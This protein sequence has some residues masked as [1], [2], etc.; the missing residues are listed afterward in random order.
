VPL[1][2]ENLG[3]ENPQPGGRR[4]AP[5]RLAIVQGFINSRWELSSPGKGETFSTPGRLGDWLRTRG[6]IGRGPRLTDR[7][8]G[9][10]IAV[11]EGLRALAFTNNG[12]TLDEAA[13]AEMRRASEG[14]GTRILVEPDGPRI[15]VADDA[16]IDAAIGAVLAM[17][18]HAMADRSWLRMKACPGRE[19]GWTFYDYSR[20]QSARWCSMKVCGG[21]EKARAY[22]RRRTGEG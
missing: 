13:I 20:N 19:C 22:Y 14:A 17:T 15:V 1:T 7:D 10:A 3:L 2:G 11:R 16:G 12:R 8:L 4:P 6:L 9:R 18:A 21:R 5:T